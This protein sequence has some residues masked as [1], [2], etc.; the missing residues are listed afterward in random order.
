MTS[1]DVDA[2]LQRLVDA[3]PELGLQVAA[4]VEGQLVVDQQTGW[5]SARTIY[6]SIER[7][8]GLTCATV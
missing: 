5:E 7:S 3:G 6:A 8:L 4:Y 2:E 1:S